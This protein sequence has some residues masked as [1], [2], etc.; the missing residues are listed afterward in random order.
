LDD[1][2]AL[3]FLREYNQRCEPPW[4]EEELKHKVK[5]ASNWNP[6]KAQK[7]LGYLLA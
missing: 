6:E 1:E 7:P 4:N 5:S 2:E 3:R